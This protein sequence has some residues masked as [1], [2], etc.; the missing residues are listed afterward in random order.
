MMYPIAQLHARE[1]E[2]EA[3]RGKGAP[4][5]SHSKQVPSQGPDSG[6]PLQGLPL[7]W[8]DR[9]ISSCVCVL[10]LSLLPWWPLTPFSV[11]LLQGPSP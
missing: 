11:L 2:T 7:G 6:L 5:R 1:E 4:P 8:R 9:W 10:S 3:Q